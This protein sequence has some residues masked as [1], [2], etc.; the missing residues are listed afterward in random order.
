MKIIWFLVVLTILFGMIEFLLRKK[1]KSS[2]ISLEEPAKEVG[3]NEVNPTDSSAQ[4]TETSTSWIQNFKSDPWGMIK[5]WWGED[6]LATILLVVTV[7]VTIN[8]FNHTWWV[9]NI[10][11]VYTLLV[12]LTCV[13]AAKILPTNTKNPLTHRIARWSV[14]LVIIIT[15]THF[16]R[17]RWPLDDFERLF[18]SSSVPTPRPS[19][20]LRYGSAENAFVIDPD[21]MPPC[22][23]PRVWK[24]GKEILKDYPF[25]LAV[26]AH[27][28]GFRMYKSAPDCTPLEGQ[29]LHAQLEGGG[30]GSAAGPLQ[31]ITEHVDFCHKKGFDN[32][33]KDI[34]SHFRCGIAIHNDDARG[35]GPGAW[36]PLN[37]QALST[38]IIALPGSEFSKP[39]R[40]S[41]TSRSSIK[42]DGDVEETFWLSDGSKLIAEFDTNGKLYK[43]RANKG[44][45]G[46]EI[47]P[48]LSNTVKAIS[49]RAL[50]DT[51]V[52]GH[53]T[54]SYLILSTQR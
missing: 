31:I 48:D 17:V 53:I 14:G 23:D 21:T 54:I 15:L 13:F 45:S 39:W 2:R 41:D 4:T 46:E 10:W 50:G 26:T 30:E 28:S 47:H 35:R 43:P 1:G 51:P 8:Y 16:V 6:I 27:E 19:T 24:I 29:V 34:A 49:W 12:I 7:N 36:K 37:G 9:E 3:V 11:S 44:E 33:Y 18:T 22:A 25:L 38:R 32:I 40:M 5:K 42:W 20:Q 52:T